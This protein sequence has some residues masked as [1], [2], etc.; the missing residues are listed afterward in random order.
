MTRRSLNVLVALVTAT[1]LLLASVSVGQTATPPPVATFMTIDPVPAVKVGQKDPFTVV[2]HLTA[3][4]P[5]GRPMDGERLILAIDG[6]VDRD[7][8]T[9]A[10][11]VMRFTV[12]RQLTAGTHSLEVKFEGS[13]TGLPS[14]AS[15][16][17]TVAASDATSPSLRPTLPHWRSSRWRL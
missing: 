3:Q 13:R 2:V 17:L 7:G 4:G 8:A 15:R 5:G 10:T 6:V 9:D 16:Q 14:Q 11:G 12:R 1:A